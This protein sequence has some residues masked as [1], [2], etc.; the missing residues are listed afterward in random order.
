MKQ[1]GDIV[2]SKWTEGLFFVLL[3]ACAS[4]HNSTLWMV[5]Y[6]FGA[7]V[8]TAGLAYGIAVLCRAKN[9]WYKFPA[10]PEYVEYARRKSEELE[11][12]DKNKLY[13]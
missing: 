6:V 9:A 8:I 7:A 3:I 11:N 4:T 12:T 13:K 10:T 1:L 2:F 5:A